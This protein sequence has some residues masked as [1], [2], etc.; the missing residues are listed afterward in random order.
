MTEM[1]SKEK[2]RSIWL[3]AQRLTESTPFGRGPQAT[4]KAVEHL[5]Y[6]Q[7]DTIH[8]IERSHHHILYT[9][10]PDYQ[11]SHLHQAQALDKTV[12]EYWTHALSYVPTKHFR[13]FMPDMKRRRLS[14]GPW[15]G[16]VKPEEMQKVLRL[17]KKDGPISIRDITDDVLVEKDHDWASRKPSKKALQL[18]FY[19]GRLVISERDGM[20]KKYELIERHFEWESKPKAATRPEIL[21]YEIQRSLQAQGLVSLDSICHL[22][23]SKKPEVRKILE[24][25]V[26]QGGLVSLKVEDVTKT[27]FWIAPEA[28]ED[29]ITVNKDLVHILSPFDP[30][31]IQRKRLQALFDYEHR[32]EAYVPKEKRQYGYFAL[33]VLIGDQMV[34]AI[35]L[36][37]DREKKK[38]LMQKWTWLGK[39]KSAVNKK[40]IETELGRFENFQLR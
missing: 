7:I 20:L 35:D 15:F 4:T 5:G 32:F 16:K 9:R 33:P 40:L 25:K 23:P 36:K 13:Y 30:L 26:R 1:I 14:P 27:D 11:C 39:H 12:F 31:T 37:A 3:K 29:R 18:G 38:L 8:V 10:I 21:E 6:V 17:I 34:A 24:G 28:L 22:V 2:A 19:A